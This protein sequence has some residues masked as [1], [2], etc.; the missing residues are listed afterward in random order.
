MA[1]RGAK[2]RYEDTRQKTKASAYQYFLIS[3]ACMLLWIAIA[4]LLQIGSGLVGAVSMVVFVWI[5]L[6]GFFIRYAC[7]REALSNCD[8]PSC[9]QTPSK[10]SI[11]M[12][13]SRCGW[14]YG[15]PADAPN[16]GQRV[17]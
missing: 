3:F 9:G 16:P 14:V 15:K 1:D 17:R 7:L 8:C 10:A 6:V 2:E 11:Q 13:C 12:R 4:L 5:P